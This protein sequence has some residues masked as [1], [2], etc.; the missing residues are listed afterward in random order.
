MMHNRI[1]KLSPLMPQDGAI[2]VSIDKHERQ[3]LEHVLSEIFGDDNQIE[4]LIWAMNTNN[5]QAPNYSTN[6]EYVLVYAKDRV[7][8][9]QD[10][11]MFREP[12]PGYAEVMELVA[13]LNPDYPP[14]AAIE[15]EIRKLYQQHQIE[16]REQVEA[17]G[18]DWEDEKKNDPWKG[19]FNYKGAEYRDSSG[20]LVA[21]S[22]ARDRN[23]SIWIWQEGDASMP[24]TKQSP[25]VLIRATKT[26]DGTSHFIR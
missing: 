17:E 15:D 7:V 21:E 26:G 16:Y 11:S 6:H 1:R 18:L 8:A 10:K 4:E 25:T 20:R 12:K 22:E 9:E 2:F 14:I 19:L 23:A 3:A 5:S 24:A 13:R